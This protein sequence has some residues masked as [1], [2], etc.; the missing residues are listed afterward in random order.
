MGQDCKSSIV[1]YGLFMGWREEKSS[2]NS[3]FES[4]Y[5]KCTTAYKDILV[6]KEIMHTYSL[7]G[8]AG[9]SWLQGKHLYISP[10]YIIS[11]LGREES[12]TTKEEMLEQ[13]R[14]SIQ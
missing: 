12:R 14:H 6:I 3:I 8:V 11:Y 10:L 7:D 5:N 4:D 1:S 2:K 13:T 9:N